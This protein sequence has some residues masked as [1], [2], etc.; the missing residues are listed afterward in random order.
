MGALLREVVRA[1]GSFQPGFSAVPHCGT[2][3][4]GP[5]R[6]PRLSAVTSTP[7]QPSGRRKREEGTRSCPLGTGAGRS[8]QC[9]SQLRPAARDAG[10]GGVFCCTAFLGRTG[11]GGQ[12][13]SAATGTSTFIPA[14]GERLGPVKLWATPSPFSSSGRAPSRSH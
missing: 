3:N 5:R 7:V 8:G 1:P 14:T 12:P 13:A 4:C 11:P 10:M 6:L 2:S 9:G